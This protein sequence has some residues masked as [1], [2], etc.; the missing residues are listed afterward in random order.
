MT[1]MGPVICFAC[2][3]LRSKM[4]EDEPATCDAFP[5]GIPDEIYP[6]GADHR[7]PYPDDHGLRFLLDPRK[8]FMLRAYE[9]DRDETHR[10]PSAQ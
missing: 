8:E 5:D 1:T 4:R 10:E 6:N 2:K 3:R 9:V 7:E